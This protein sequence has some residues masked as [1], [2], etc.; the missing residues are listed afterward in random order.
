MFTCQTIDTSTLSNI[1]AH[2]YRSRH[3]CTSHWSILAIRAADKF[4]Q[5]F[6]K[7]A[8]K[9]WEEPAEGNGQRVEEDE[10]VRIRSEV[11][12]IPDQVWFFVIDAMRM[13]VQVEIGL[14]G[15]RA[16]SGGLEFPLGDVAENGPGTMEGRYEEVDRLLE[17]LAEQFKRCQE[18]ISTSYSRPHHVSTKCA[19]LSQG[20]MMGWKAR[21]A[22]FSNQTAVRNAD[23]TSWSGVEADRG[24]TH[25]TPACQ[26]PQT[27][28]PSGNGF[29]AAIN[30]ASSTLLEEIFAISEPFHATYS[31][32]AASSPSTSYFNHSDEISLSNRLFNP[33]SITTV[34]DN[35]HPHTSSSTDATLRAQNTSWQ[36][37]SSLVSPNESDSWEGS[38]MMRQGLGSQYWQGNK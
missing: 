12:V 15:Q 6:L 16:G 34:V 8:Q 4:L 17:A 30:P 19:E 21:R 31:T 24:L 9:T 10:T 13:L 7:V 5:R 22:T 35:S 18:M 25:G 38:P 23:D 3:S 37:S 1:D 27:S 29:S 36:D 33:G 20:L 11:V 2:F 28:I 26:M 14:I 32:S